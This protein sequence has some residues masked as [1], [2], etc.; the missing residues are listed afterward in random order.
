MVKATN[1]IYHDKAR[2][3]ALVLPDHALIDREYLRF[4][5]RKHG[6]R[7]RL[8]IGVESAYTTEFLDGAEKPAEGRHHCE[9]AKTSGWSGMI[10]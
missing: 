6:N 3:S 7:Y 4:G 1:L 9:Q 10:V 2:P 8:D 5:S